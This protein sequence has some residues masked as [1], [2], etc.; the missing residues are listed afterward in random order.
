M[1]R[2]E[3]Y[4]TKSVIAFMTYILPTNFINLCS[5]TLLMELWVAL[6]ELFL[7][8]L[9][10]ALNENIFDSLFYDNN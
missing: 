1:G 2:N 10:E 8:P 4:T 5:K 3:D 7:K 9:N 6:Y